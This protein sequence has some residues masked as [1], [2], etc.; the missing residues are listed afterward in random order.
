MYFTTKKCQFILHFRRLSRIVAFLFTI[1]KKEICKDLFSEHFTDKSREISR[2]SGRE[3]LITDNELRNQGDQQ[4]SLIV[5]KITA[6]GIHNSRGIREDLFFK[7][8]GKYFGVQVQATIVY[9]VSS[10]FQPGLMYDITEDNRSFNS[11]K[12][13]MKRFIGMS[14]EHVLSEQSKL[15]IETQYRTIRQKISKFFNNK[16]GGMQVAQFLI[17]MKSQRTKLIVT[18]SLCSVEAMCMALQ[19]K[20]TWF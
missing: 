2:L 18:W 8:I 19:P 5:G 16:Y 14:P 13:T 11:R 4:Y 3:P 9:L 20:G 6:F 10:A 17:Y 15:E 7:C 12:M 1:K